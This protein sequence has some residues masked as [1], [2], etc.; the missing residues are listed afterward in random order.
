MRSRLAPV[1]L[2]ALAAG[3]ST[4]ARPPSPA[5]PAT[6]PLRVGLA[7]DSPPVAF[8]RAGEIQ[9]IEPDFASALAAELG[10]PL[11][12]VQYDWVDLIPALLSG[13]VDV[14]MS[15]MTV[16]PARSVRVAFAD[17]WLHSGLMAAMRR[18]DASRFQTVQS[19][20]T[21]RATVGVRE[22][23]TGEKFV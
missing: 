9:G 1:L 4:A 11:Q 19:I 6:P 22:G 15:G 7:P 12:L 8:R 10:R 20:L 21:T 2:L 16:T 3:C 13:R 17:P 23:T 5:Q 18:E 14:I